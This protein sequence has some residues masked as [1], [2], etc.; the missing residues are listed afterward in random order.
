MTPFLSDHLLRTVFSMTTLSPEI[1]LAVLVNQPPHLGGKKSSPPKKRNP[2]HKVKVMGFYTS[3]P[4]IV[5]LIEKKQQPVGEE[6][7][8]DLMDPSD[9]GLAK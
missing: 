8:V 1:R 9:C 5:T 7:A 2:K 3:P 4:P 6:P